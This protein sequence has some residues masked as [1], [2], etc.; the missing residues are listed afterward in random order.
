VPSKKEI[1]LQQE[2]NANRF[3]FSLAEQQ[4]ELDRSRE[5][6]PNDQL[7]QLEFDRIQRILDDKRRKVR[8]HKTQLA[9]K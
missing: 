9:N 7:R 5:L 3:L 4:N 8:R 6:F 2:R 1:L